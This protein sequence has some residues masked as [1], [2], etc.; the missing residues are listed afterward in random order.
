VYLPLTAK[1][2]AE[3][4]NVCFD[5]FFGLL[6]TCSFREANVTCFLFIFSPPRP[7]SC[8]IFFCSSPLCKSSSKFSSV[9]FRFWFCF[10]LVSSRILFLPFRL[11]S[12]CE[13][14][15]PHI[16]TRTHKDGS[17]VH[18]M[19]LAPGPRLQRWTVAHQEEVLHQLGVA[20]FRAGQ[21]GGRG[22]LGR[23]TDSH[24]SDH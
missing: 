10:L 5:F 11:C 21:K 24:E 8:H 22:Q 17:D 13:P 2:C 3:T 12:W 6:V 16:P 15:T 19:R 14:T 20:Q 23:R 7:A 9:S 4:L 1:S 18:P